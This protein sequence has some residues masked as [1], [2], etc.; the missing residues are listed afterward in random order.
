MS[1]L[2]GLGGAVSFIRSAAP[3]GLVWVAGGARAD[4][5]AYRLS[6]LRR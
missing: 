5:R 3:L 1:R 4:A 6:R 2:E